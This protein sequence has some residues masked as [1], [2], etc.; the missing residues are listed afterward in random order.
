MIA[1]LDEGGHINL[2]LQPLLIMMQ[3]LTFISKERSVSIT[4]A[5]KI[6]HYIDCELDAFAAATCQSLNLAVL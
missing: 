4:N 2:T 5:S 6:I 3:G 1:L